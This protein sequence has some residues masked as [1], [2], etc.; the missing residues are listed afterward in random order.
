MWHGKTIAVV[1]P[2]Y[3]ERDSIARCIKA[4]E[5]LGVVDDIV[6][7]NNNAEPGTS[8]EVAGTSAREI[9]EP[10]QGYGAAIQRGLREVDAD[11]GRDDRRAADEGS[12]TQR[13]QE[14]SGSSHGR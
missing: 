11:L 7:V 6:V 3:R 10:V 2:T 5:A 4:F 12:E 13:A 9:F 14:S 8:D 1:L